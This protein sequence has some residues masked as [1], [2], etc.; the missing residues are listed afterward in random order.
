MPDRKLEVKR[1]D[2]RLIDQ[3]WGQLAPF[4]LAGLEKCNGEIDISQLRAAVVRG[5]VEVFSVHCE[6]GLVGAVAIE[7]INFPNYRV[8]HVV[9]IGG[10]HMFANAEGFDQLKAWVK[11]MG[12]SYIQGWCNDAVAKLW[13]SRLGMKKTYTVMRSPT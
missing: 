12:A 8:A 2:R 4:L 1:V 3:V 10:R 5:D 7:F 11:S 13:E 9:S 6:A